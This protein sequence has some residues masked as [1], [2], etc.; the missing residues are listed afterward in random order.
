LQ[1][2]NASQKIKAGSLYKE[3][4]KESIKC[5]DGMIAIVSNNS[6][7]SKW[8]TS[9][10]TG[11]QTH[12]PKA[13]IIPIRL[14]STELEK[15]TPGL[16]AYQA[17]NFQECMLTGFTN[18][19]A[20]FN[21]EFLPKSHS[22]DSKRR[23]EGR[24]L[25]GDR[26]RAHYIKQRMRKCFWEAYSKTTGSEKFE[27][28]DLGFRNVNRIINS[29]VQSAEDFEYINDTGS[30]TVPLEALSKTIYK[31]I[32]YWRSREFDHK[33]T[34]VNVIESIAE[35]LNDIFTVTLLD[36]RLVQE[37]RNGAK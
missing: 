24:R 7:T 37:R 17:V 18:L 5:C 15:I 14:D 12:H 3:A 34:A 10:I 16:S 35:D 32:E 23:N 1:T 2:W 22:K 13:P 21:I 31:N 6:L 27:L 28:M 26:R 36:R 11:F 29:L 20:R 4:I 19:F 8:V 33:I 9:E 30:S 25:N